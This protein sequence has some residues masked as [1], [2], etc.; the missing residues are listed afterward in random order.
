MSRRLV[1]V[2]FVL[3]VL[4]AVLVGAYYTEK[5]QSGRVNNVV[6]NVYN[7]NASFNG[8][9]VLPQPDDP[10]VYIIRGYVDGG[11]LEDPFVVYTYEDGTKLVNKVGFNLAYLDA[12]NNLQRVKV[13]LLADHGG[14][15]VYLDKVIAKELGSE[16]DEVSFRKD[17]LIDGRVVDLLFISNSS[18]LQQYKELAKS[19]GSLNEIQMTWFDIMQKY[20]EVNGNSLLK[21]I[22]TGRPLNVPLIPFTP[23]STIYGKTPVLFKNN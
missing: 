7:G 22:E 11:P 21:L 3:V 14:E 19:K 8:S 4:T 2:L 17:I 18:D 12:K 1:V 9:V 5:S 23:N 10:G 13:S 20:L 16:L 6:D 15:L